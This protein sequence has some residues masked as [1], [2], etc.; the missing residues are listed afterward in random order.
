MRGLARDARA[1]TAIV[2]LRVGPGGA[3]APLDEERIDD[4]PVGPDETQR[5]L[6]P[7]P[8][9]QGPEPLLAHLPDRELEHAPRLVRVRVDYE[10]PPLGQAPLEPEHPVPPAA[11]GREEAFRL[12]LTSMHDLIAGRLWDGNALLPQTVERPPDILPDLSVLR[13]RLEPDQERGD[14]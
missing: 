9:P 7:H 4:A 14:G 8:L 11:E 6:A 10:G 2:P 5:K 1:H 12:R 3:R 13:A